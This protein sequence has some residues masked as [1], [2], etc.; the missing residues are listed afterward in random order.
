MP[1][2]FIELNQS[3]NQS[4]HFKFV[5]IYGQGWFDSLR[6]EVFENNIHVT[7]LCPGPVF[8][9]I[10]DIAFTEEIGKVYLLLFLYNS[11][12]QQYDVTNIVQICCILL[13]VCFKLHLVHAIC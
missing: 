12:R 11:L 3:I 1:I 13:L 2:K 9:N 8:S 10:L 6:L 4:K 5:F 7:N